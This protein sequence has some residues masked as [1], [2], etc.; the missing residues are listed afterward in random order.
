M[1][2]V[3]DIGSQ[4]PVH[5]LDGRRMAGAGGQGHQD[6]LSLYLDAQQ[7]GLRLISVYT[8]VAIQTFSEDSDLF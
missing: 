8:K 5:L 4:Q 6:H 3:A 1:L 7:V 2:D